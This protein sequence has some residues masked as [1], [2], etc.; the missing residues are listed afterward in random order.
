MAK[1]R[2]IIEREKVLELLDKYTCGVNGEYIYK[3]DFLRELEELTTLNCRWIDRINKV[4]DIIRNVKKALLYNRYFGSQRELCEAINIT[5]NTL[6]SWEGVGITV[7]AHRKY[8]IKGKCKFYDLQEL[9]KAL[10]MYEE[11]EK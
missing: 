11:K 7:K 2:H 10:E 8:R 1:E 4:K 6:A 9:L 3:D 5:P